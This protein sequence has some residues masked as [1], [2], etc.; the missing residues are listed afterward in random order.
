MPTKMIQSKTNVRTYHMYHYINTNK[1]VQK[2]HCKRQFFFTFLEP[3]DNPHVSK[4][5]QIFQK[6]FKAT[7]Q[8]FLI[9]AKTLIFTKL[10]GI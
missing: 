4:Q 3:S 6:R 2:K 9:L 10:P 8:T 1:K 5:G 7:H